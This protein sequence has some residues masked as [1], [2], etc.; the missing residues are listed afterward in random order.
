MEANTLTNDN[1][2]PQSMVIFIEALKQNKSLISLNVANNKLDGD[3][4]KEFKHCLEQNKTLIDFEFGFNNFLLK[5][6]STLCFPD[7]SFRF[8]KFRSTSAVT[9][10]STMKNVS[11]SG[12]KGSLCAAKMRPFKTCI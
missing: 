4:G 3:L 7:L 10:Q 2:S 9:R 8:A 12:K 11:A 5:D 1:E 6:V